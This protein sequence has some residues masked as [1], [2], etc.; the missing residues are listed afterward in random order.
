VNVGKRLE[1]PSGVLVPKIL[2]TAVQAAKEADI[3]TQVYY[4]R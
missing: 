4:S 3:L 1:G 2:V